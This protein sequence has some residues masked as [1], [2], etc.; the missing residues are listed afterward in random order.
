MTGLMKKRCPV[1]FKNRDIFISIGKRLNLIHVNDLLYY[2]FES[3]VKGK[4]PNRQ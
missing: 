4:S 3:L 2:R 1:E